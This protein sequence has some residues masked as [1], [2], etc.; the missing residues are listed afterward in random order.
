MDRLGECFSDIYQVDVFI[1][2]VREGI[3][4]RMCTQA[5]HKQGE[6]VGQVD[7]RDDSVEGTAIQIGGQREKE[8][9]RSSV[10]VCVSCVCI[11]IKLHITA[12]PGCVIFIFQC[13]R[14]GSTL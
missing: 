8:R 10:C 6:R 13:Y 12:Q 14:Y 11:F 1:L 7:G 2:W 4:R 5:V 9:I 3:L